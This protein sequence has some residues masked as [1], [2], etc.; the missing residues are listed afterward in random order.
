MGKCFLCFTETDT[1]CCD[2]DNNVFYCGPDHLS[3][4]MYQDTC[5]PFSVDTMPGVGRVVTAVRDIKAGEL[6]LTEKAAVSGPA[7]KTTPVCVNCCKAWQVGGALCDT[8]GWPVCGDTCQQGSQHVLECQTLARCPPELR[9]KFDSNEETNVFAAIIPL[10]LA[11]LSGQETPLAQ[12]LGLLMDHRD[13]IESRPGFSDKWDSPVVQFLTE[14][15][16]SKVS[17]E[18]LLRGTEFALFV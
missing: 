17:K 11:L 16:D 9:H 15:F 8:C 13:D 3:S 18:S 4:H 10:R 14:T 2:C 6:I 12:R 5:L 7:N 1:K